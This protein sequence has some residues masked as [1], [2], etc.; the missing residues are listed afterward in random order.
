MN[1]F[2]FGMVI[3]LRKQQIEIFRRMFFSTVLLDLEEIVYCAKCYNPH[4]SKQFFYDL[5]NNFGT[6]IKLVR[7]YKK[8]FNQCMKTPNYDT[9]K[10]VTDVRNSALDVKVNIQKHLT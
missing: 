5:N 8:L 6:Y 3:K 1:I 4:I 2:D 9:F 10:R 7:I